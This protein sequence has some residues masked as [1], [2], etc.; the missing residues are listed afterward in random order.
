MGEIIKSL[1][2]QIIP[3]LAASSGA[4]LLNRIFGLSKAENQQNAFNAQQAQLN[5]NFQAMQAQNQNAFNAEQAQLNRNFQADQAATQW[6]RGV[7]DMRAAGLNP[8]LAYGQGGASAMSGSAASSAGLPAG[9]AASGSGR[10]LGVSLNL[11]V[12]Q[13]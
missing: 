7:S 12:L 13:S 8:A 3:G 9:S 10:G 2:S 1:I 6:Q 4:G 11:I 5:R